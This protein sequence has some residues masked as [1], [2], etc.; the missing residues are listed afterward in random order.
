MD[1]D[2]T[3][4][5]CEQHARWG[6][7]S[8]A[9][10]REQRERAYPGKQP[11]LIYQGEIYSHRALTHLFWR[12]LNPFQDSVYILASAIKEM[13][14]NETITDAPKDCDDSGTIWE[15]GNLCFNNSN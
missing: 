8:A 15:S 6:A 9:G 1:S 5:E 4:A 3:S 11:V 7:R 2:R 10:L 14:M 12:I 13:T